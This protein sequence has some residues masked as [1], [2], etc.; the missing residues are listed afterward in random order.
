MRLFVASVLA[1]SFPMVLLGA[2]SGDSQPP[3]PVVRCESGMV[4]DKKSKT[5]VDAKDSRLSPDE[6]YQTV[7]HLAYTGAYADAQIILAALPADDDRTLTYL[8]FTTRKMGDAAA[9]MAYYA[10]A[11]E[12]NPANVLARSYMGQGLVEQGE[13]A[14][15][16]DQLRAIRAHG[17]AG[18]WAEAS[19]RTAIATG[20]SHSY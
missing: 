15:A 10:R 13:M 4:Y 20:R 12:R 18:S 6:L 5:C 2:G 3:K 8:G 17:G 19:L 7:R 1:A 9:G 14:Q 16:L 11:L